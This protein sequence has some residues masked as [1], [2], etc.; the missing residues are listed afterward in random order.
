MS[1]RP[2]TLRDKRRYLLLRVDPAGTPVDQKE[3]YYTIADAITSLYGDAAAA[4]MIQAVVAAEGGYIFIRCRRGTEREVATAIS[5]V[6]S[7]RDTRIALRILAASG[8]MESLRERVRSLITPEAAAELPGDL[9]FDNKPVSPLYC[10][11]QKV[12][13]IEKGFKNTHRYFLTTE[14]L[15]TP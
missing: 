12:D 14:D 4:V 2:P 11:G 13:V 7:C 15:E 9:I 8:T 6:T 3:L 1:P 10:H 5:T